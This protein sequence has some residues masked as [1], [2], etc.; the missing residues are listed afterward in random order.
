MLL[1]E[2]LG[3]LLGGGWDHHTAVH[4]ECRW[5]VVKIT[6]VDLKNVFL[7]LKTGSCPLL[8]YSC[9]L[10]LQHSELCFSR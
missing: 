9:H 7:K 5:L 3:S 8:K 1:V 6:G 10:A 4:W 2:I